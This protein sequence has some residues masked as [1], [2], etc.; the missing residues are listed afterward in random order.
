MFM[1]SG[2]KVFGGTTLGNHSLDHW[3]LIEID[4]KA[5]VNPKLQNSKIEK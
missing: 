3:N 1:A 5:E 2:S 4:E